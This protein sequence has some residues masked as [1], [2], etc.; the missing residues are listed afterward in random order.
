M[1]SE[2]KIVKC[3]VNEK[4]S[5]SLIIFYIKEQKVRGWQRG[6]EGEDA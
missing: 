6:T 4:F 2:N 1:P 5:L 3:H